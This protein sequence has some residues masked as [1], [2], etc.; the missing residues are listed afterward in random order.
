MSTPS[1]SSS[2]HV[3]LPPEIW[4]QVAEAA[5]A[6]PPRA[7]GLPE[8]AKRDLQNLSLVSRPF[9]RWSSA[10]LYGRITVTHDQIA[11]LRTT[12]LLSAR[13]PHPNTITLAQYIRA[14]RVVICL[15]EKDRHRM[16]EEL[17]A[18]LVLVSDTVQRLFLDV[19]LNGGEL[20]AVNSFHTP[21]TLYN[22][23]MSIRNVSE[24]T[25]GNDCHSEMDPGTVPRSRLQWADE[26]QA[27]MCKGSRLSS[28]LDRLTLTVSG[29]VSLSTIATIKD[30]FDN[31]QSLTFIIFGLNLEWVSLILLVLT[32]EALDGLAV[33][34]LE[35]LAFLVVREKGKDM[36]AMVTSLVEQ[37]NDPS[38]AP[39]HQRIAI[40]VGLERS[41]E[42]KQ[43]PRWNQIAEAITVGHEL[44]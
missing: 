4:I 25:L 31:L 16:I 2:S 17:T 3:G 12:L 14:L 20:H 33:N 26:V 36:V 6:A 18:L 23:I 24:L 5:A 8:A 21:F 13:S 29:G 40:R 32:P 43:E 19:D 7:Y 9:H 22:A 38:L 39:C 30:H 28:K 35:K 1:L 44:Y 37:L 34:G 27:T 15:P 42:D 10:V 11:R 41:G